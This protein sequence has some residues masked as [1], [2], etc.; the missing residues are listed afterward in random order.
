MNAHA[1]YTIASVFAYLSLFVALSLSLSLSLALSLCQSVSR[2]D[3]LSGVC[4]YAVKFV[5]DRTFDFKMSL[6]QR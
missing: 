3:R 1:P 6:S 5:T 2:S 4:T